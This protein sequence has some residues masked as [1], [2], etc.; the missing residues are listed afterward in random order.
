MAQ[1]Q[2]A[3]IPL[4]NYGPLS[5]LLDPVVSGT[6]SPRLLSCSNILNDLPFF[7]QQNKAQFRL[8]INSKV[9][10][11]QTPVVSEGYKSSQRQNHAWAGK[12]QPSWAPDSAATHMVQRLHCYSS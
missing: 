9:L 11:A 7:P 5:S 12:V 4:R 3:A 2:S 1:K 10:L 6:R 8:Y